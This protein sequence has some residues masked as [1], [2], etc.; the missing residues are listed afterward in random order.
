MKD[1]SGNTQLF[2]GIIKQLVVPEKLTYTWAGNGGGTQQ[3]KTL[4]RID[5]IEKGDQTAVKLIHE[6][7]R[8][9]Q[10]RISYEKSWSFLFE[11]LE[12]YL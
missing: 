10:M 5:F 1:K 9:E 11:Q 6:N 8:D 3:M 7:F 2:G 4:L 12:K